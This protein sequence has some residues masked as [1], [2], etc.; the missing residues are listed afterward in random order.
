[1]WWPAA[2]RG[3]ERSAPSHKKAMRGVRAWAGG[4]GV[5]SLFAAVGVGDDMSL[6]EL[7]WAP[8]QLL[9]VTALPSSVDGVVVLRVVGELELITVQRLREQLEPYLS[10]G[11]CGVVLDFTEVSF[12]AACAIGL[13]VELAD[14]ARAAG[15]TLRLVTRTPRVRRALEVGLAEQRIA[16]ACTVAQAVAECTA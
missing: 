5:V 3:A 11:H 4:I 15:I 9:K 16:A 6:S 8:E 7:G 13:L 10:S 2:V 14:Q 12:L 1:M